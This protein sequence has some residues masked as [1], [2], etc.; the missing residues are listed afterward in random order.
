MS[1]SRLP[2]GP[3]TDDITGRILERWPQTA[4][5]R[6]D[7][8][9]FFSF[10]PSNW[11]NYATIVWTD[12]F[13]MGGPSR[14]SRP[15]VFRLNIGLGKESFRRVAGDSADFDHA[16]LDTLMPHPLYAKQHWVCILNPSHLTFEETVWPLL[17]EAHD[18]L[19]RARNR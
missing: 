12:A 19:A 13:D 5:A 8:G 10:D 11:P 2:D 4:V 7:G 1:S 15:G 16:A 6:T 3:D 17:V 14:L 9:V 18:R